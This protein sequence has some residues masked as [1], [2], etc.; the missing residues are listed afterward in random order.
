MKTRM[1][2]AVSEC[3]EFKSKYIGGMTADEAEKLRADTD[4]LKQIAD[5]S[6]SQAATL[7]ALK[8]V[9]PPE[10]NPPIATNVQWNMIHPT[11]TA[12][13]ERCEQNL[14]KA[15][16]QLLELQNTCRALISLVQLVSNN[17]WYQHFPIN[18]VLFAEEHNELFSGVLKNESDIAKSASSKV[19]MLIDTV[20]SLQS[21]LSRQENIVEKLRHEKEL[22]ETKLSCYESSDILKSKGDKNNLIGQLS[23]IKSEL[24]NAKRELRQSS[25]KQKILEANVNLLERANSQLERE[26]ANAALLCINDQNSKVGS[27]LGPLLSVN[28]NC[29]DQTVEKVGVT[30]KQLSI[31]ISRYTQDLHSLCSR[32][33]SVRVNRMKEHKVLKQLSCLNE[34]LK[35]KD[36]TISA[37]KQKVAELEK[38][39]SIIPSRSTRHSH[40]DDSFSSFGTMPSLGN[41][42]HTHENRRLY[43]L[44]LEEAFKLIATKDH[45]LKDLSRRSSEAENTRKCL[46]KQLQDTT[47]HSNLLKT[48]ITTLVATL[49]EKESKVAEL[50]KNFG[51]SKADLQDTSHEN[52]RL[53]AKLSK[54]SKERKEV[55]DKIKTL[56]ADLQRSK[57]VLSVTRQGR[58]R[59]EAKLSIESEKSVSAQEQINK[60]NKE[61]YDV[62]CKLNAA[63]QEKI[64]SNKKARVVSSK[65]KSLTRKYDPEANEQVKNELEKRVTVLNQTVSGLA[66]QNSKLRADVTRL[67]KEKED[68]QKLNRRPSTS[69]MEQSKSRTKCNQCKTLEA[70]ITSLERSLQCEQKQGSEHRQM[71]EMYQQRSFNLEKALKNSVEDESKYSSPRSSPSAV[72]T[73]FCSFFAFPCL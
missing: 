14:S 58:A 57:R 45:E 43:E 7:L 39:E 69:S 40:T 9:T 72:C 60:L 3:S 70:H 5:L 12:Q 13:F 71:L 6:Q 10:G 20:A 21:Q 25:D 38:R 30:L 35:V 66:T 63:T 59:S 67:K 24:F 4:N 68:W 48:D 27:I 64:A 23:E 16:S 56:E 28:L 37:L 32:Y 31:V 36:K 2:S 46:L 73:L 34:M 50:E 54:L 49:A 61:L 47:K 19:G 1:E 51:Q 52:E 42:T 44:R 62:K 29:T 33:S 15:Q 18:Q 22:L 55:E 17:N 65:L 41:L 11:A 53:K 26:N 8:T